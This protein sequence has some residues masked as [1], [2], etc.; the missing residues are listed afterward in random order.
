[1]KFSQIANRLTGY[2]RRPVGCRGNQWRWRSP[3][4]S[5]SVA[6]ARRTAQSLEYEAQVSQQ[7]S[8]SCGLDQF[9]ADNAK[10]RSYLFPC[11]RVSCEATSFNVVTE[12]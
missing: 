7:G 4:L 9:S 5:G 11:R 10:H 1:M 2:R 8:N 6:G 12:P 3:G